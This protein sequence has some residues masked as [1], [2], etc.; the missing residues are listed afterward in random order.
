MAE[1][2]D[3]CN[4]AG[5]KLLECSGFYNPASL[6]N[7]DVSTTAATSTDTMRTA[8]RWSVFTI[9]CCLAHSSYALIM[10]KS[11]N[12][13]PWARSSSPSA[14]VKKMTPSPL[15]GRCR[16]AHPNPA[17]EQQKRLSPKSI[18]LRILDTTSFVT[19]VETIG[20]TAS[21]LGFWGHTGLAIVSVAIV[22][23]VYAYFFRPDNPEP[24]QAGILNRCPW[25]FIFFHD[26]KQG[27]KDSPTW[28]VL[29][30][31][32]LWRLSKIKF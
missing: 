1:F 15:V 8:L 9:L 21:I 5:A 7:L 13:S 2:S 12:P 3:V 14:L 26:V 31:L 25:P 19:D 10:I 4:E 20:S 11:P 18:A 28:I 27:F 32:A 22:K 24:K 16:L 17:I 23:T 6:T 29:T 30:W